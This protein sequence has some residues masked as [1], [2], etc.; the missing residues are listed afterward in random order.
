M[1]VFGFTF[2]RWP[3]AGRHEKWFDARLTEHERMVARFKDTMAEHSSDL[4]GVADAI[5][6]SIKVQQDDLTRI[7]ALRAKVDNIIS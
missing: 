3:Y 7:N 1:R 5:V 2:V 6:A 4:K